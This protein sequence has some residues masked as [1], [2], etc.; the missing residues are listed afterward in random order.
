MPGSPN[1]FSLDWT[2]APDDPEFDPNIID[3]ELEGAASEYWELHDEEH[4]QFIA[5]HME[6]YA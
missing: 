2:T 5:R 3:T 6:Q 4:E 1:C